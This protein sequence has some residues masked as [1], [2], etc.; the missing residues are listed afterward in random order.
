MT[1]NFSVWKVPGYR[2]TMAAIAAA[3]G[4]WSLLLPVVPLAVLDA[5]GSPTLAG[6]T[7][8]VFM[9][10]T[11]LTQMITP[12]LLRRVGYLPVMAVSAFMLGV[13]ALGHLL[14][15]APAAVLL[16]SALRGV[17]FGA[18]TVAESALIAELVPIGYLGKATGMMGVFIGLSQMAFLP[19]GL[20]MAEH[21]GFDS[22]YWAAAAFGLFGMLMCLRVP[23]IKAA[24]VE[25]NSEL[26]TAYAPTWKLVAV[27]ALTLTTLSMSFG[28][29]SSF[30]PAAVREIDPVTGAVLGGLMLSIAGGGAMV[31]RYVAGAVADR[32]GRPGGLMIPGQVAGALGMFLMASTMFGG[33]SVWWLVPAAVA[34]GGAFGVVQ[35]E[36]LLSMFTRLP[37]ERVS[38]ASAL[39]NIFYD[40]G[41]GLGS[42]I[43][44]MA[45]TSA[46]G[47]AAFAPS[48]LIG[49]IIITAGVSMT[50]LD[51]FLGRHR[52]VEHNNIR[53]RLQRMRKV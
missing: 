51:A 9:A 17:G 11:V 46:A 25:K 41:T 15:M 53:T 40:S 47:G 34:F 42:V 38:D 26:L 13:P 28:V 14:G 10:A 16:F 35:N 45:V 48:F 33:W 5:G 31:F 21:F 18:L 36:A 39:W 20:A 52:L 44:A 50:S 22:T 4:A 12:A 32:T 29:V 23:N 27:P 6:W 2:T 49:A 37:R 19:I 1:E 43:L 24:A 8:G 3:F 7:T 30:L